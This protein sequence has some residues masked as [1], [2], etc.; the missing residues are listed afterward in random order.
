M[1]LAKIVVSGKVT[2]NPEKRFTQNNLP[3]TTFVMDINAADE[4]LVKVTGL[5]A[6]A[7]NIENTL[8]TG[9]N[10][11]VEGRPQ[12]D[13]VQDTNGKDK[14]YIEIQAS[15]VEKIGA[16]GAPVA[17]P[18]AS[19]PAN[20]E[21]GIVKFSTEETAETLIDEDEIPF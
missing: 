9:D 15:S 21:E 8:K 18:A 17:A 5:G 10:V 13:I 16:I 1:S 6:L 12:V 20:K 11:L 2:K 19:K 4:T 14:R 7:E 3:I